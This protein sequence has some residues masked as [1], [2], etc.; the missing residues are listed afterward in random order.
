MAI[1]I[2]GYLKEISPGKVCGDDLQYDPAFTALE[3]M[4]KGKPEQQMGDTII[5][6]EPPNWREIKKYSEEL[7]ARTIDLR[8]LI[9]YL[10]ALIALQGFSGLQDGLTLIRILTEQRWDS[11]HPQLDPED[12]NDPTER[13]NVLMS[14]CDNEIMLRPLQQ[15]PL[16]ESKALGKFNFRDISIAL[17]KTTATSS[18]K[19]VN[20]ITLDAAVQ[21]IELDQLQQTL[22]AITASLENL[23]Q[24]EALVTNHIG[25]G[26][27]PSFI[28]LRSFLKESKLFLMAAL[29]KRGVGDD[30]TTAELLH[31]DVTTVAV[32]KSISGV[33]NNNQDVIRTLNL[34]CDYYNKH[35]P[36][37][38]VPL[39]IDRA[40]RLVGKNFMDVIKDIAPTGISEASIV[41]GRQQDENE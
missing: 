21:D 23:N 11:I 10:R 9:G 36:S 8:V 29:E 31:E 27:A 4:L 41:L 26:E 34:V 38:P 32:T 35:E 39:F 12:D 5:E 40:I 1:D 33:I 20:P 30:S 18:E 19:E 13:V 15:K 6:A 3:Q 7:L 28:D 2:D 17:G 37:S 22:Q 14:L 24:L 16:V 25:V